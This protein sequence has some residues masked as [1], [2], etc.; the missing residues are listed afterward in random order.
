MFCLVLLNCFLL[1][2]THSTAEYFPVLSENEENF[3]EGDS[4]ANMESGIGVITV[5]EALSKEDVNFTS[6]EAS[7]AVHRT[8]DN[9]LPDT[10]ESNHGDEAD[11]TPFVHAAS[12]KASTQPPKRCSGSFAD[13]DDLLLDL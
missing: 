12:E 13:E 11:R 1:R 6:L 4:T 9:A 10:A 5:N 7:S 8:C 2:Q 3:E